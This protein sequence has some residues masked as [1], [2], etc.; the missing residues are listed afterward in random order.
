M[1]KTSVDAW[2]R[3]LKGDFGEQ[4]LHA[5]EVDG[6]WA[7]GAS[8]GEEV[9]NELNAVSKAKGDQDLVGVSVV[10]VQPAT[11]VQLC[12]NA[13][14]PPG[15]STPTWTGS[16]LPRVSRMHFCDSRLPASTS[17]EQRAASR[18]TAWGLMCWAR[19]PLG[20]AAGNLGKEAQAVVMALGQPRVA[21]VTTS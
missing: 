13:S 1:H 17:H 19:T 7:Q 5:A 11:G 15:A 20:P 2:A 4:E 9:L 3:I 14:T 18:P 6:L 16:N 12:S 10:A 8:D 21:A